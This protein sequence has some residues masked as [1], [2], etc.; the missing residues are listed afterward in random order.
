M[1]LLVVFALFVAVGEVIAVS[2]GLLLDDIAPS[3]SL[4]IALALIFAVLYLSFPAAVIAT[5]RSAAHEEKTTT[6]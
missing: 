6:V 2:M 5:R 1:R 4:P 3:V